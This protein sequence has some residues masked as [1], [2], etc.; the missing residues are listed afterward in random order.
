M[1]TLGGITYGLDPSWITSQEEDNC[2]KVRNACAA[3]IADLQ[4][5]DDDV[6][7]DLRIVRYLRE[8][9]GHVQKVI[10]TF[11]EFLEWRITEQEPGGTV[12]EWRQEVIGRERD[13]FEKWHKQ[14][15]NP[16]EPMHW[17]AGNDVNGMPLVIMPAGHVDSRRWAEDRDIR[18][19]P[20]DMDWKFACQVSEWASWYLT[21]ISREKKKVH[22]FC[23]IID[24][25]GEGEDG[26]QTVLSGDK[27]HTEF[28]KRVLA[29][30]G[31]FYPCQ[32]ARVNV[33]NARWQFSLLWRIVKLLLSEKQRNTVNIIG[34]MD[35]PANQKELMQTWPAEHLL[36]DYG[37]ILDTLL[38]I[39][40]CCDAATARQIVHDRPYVE[41]QIPAS[42]AARV[43]STTRGTARRS[44]FS[45]SVSS[46]LARSGPGEIS[47]GP[48]ERLLTTIGM[49]P[50]GGFQTI[51]AEEAVLDQK[52]ALASQEEKIS[53]IHGR[54][55]VPVCHLTQD[56]PGWLC[57]V[58]IGCERPRQPDTDY[59]LPQ[60]YS[61]A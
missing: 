9:D 61:S 45:M 52:I 36:R 8:A 1:T 4:C 22:Y 56:R 42:S 37:G 54:D 16:Y 12:E 11:Q 19:Y 46:K 41:P 59:S 35:N 53:P 15:M 39:W 27:R 40:P 25:K 28:R 17:N 30:I 5:T 51:V 55:V 43:R 29:C 58:G 38:W 47:A 14:R 10:L 24:M 50:V 23:R 32:D 34:P 33:I 60:T 31:R 2:K 6:I 26:R 57:T 48:R 18:L 44:V 3:Q 49:P 13:D 7:G 21:K 20:Y